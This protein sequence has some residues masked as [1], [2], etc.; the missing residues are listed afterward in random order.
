MPRFRLFQ[1]EA[2][3]SDGRCCQRNQVGLS[4]ASVRSVQTEWGTFP[5]RDGHTSR[6][7]NFPHSLRA[8]FHF[9]CGTSISPSCSPWSVTTFK[10]SLHT[11]APLSFSSCD[12]HRNC[13][14][15]LWLYVRVTASEQSADRFTS[16]GQGRIQK[17]GLGGVKGWGL[18]PTPPLSVPSLP[19]PPSLPVPSP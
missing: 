12:Q 13:T 2:G 9:A 15:I 17:Y 18:V 5:R 16:H 6:R 4:T 8:V 19:L 3:F 10:K 1:N 7:G 11:S 14:Q